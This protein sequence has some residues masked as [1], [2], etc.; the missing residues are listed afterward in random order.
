VLSVASDADPLALA[1]RAPWRRVPF[2]QM[3]GPDRLLLTLDGLPHAGL[4]GTV[5]SSG[6]ARR[7]QFDQG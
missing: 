6:E 3:P 2:E 7:G 5:P 1:E 4:T